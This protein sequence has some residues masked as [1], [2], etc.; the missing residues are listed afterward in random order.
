MPIPCR[1]LGSIAFADRSKANS[2]RQR[3]S[4]FVDAESYLISNLEAS[5]LLLLILLSR[6]STTGQRINGC[7]SLK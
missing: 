2:L 6:R 4:F 3:V 5:V 7:V 1:V